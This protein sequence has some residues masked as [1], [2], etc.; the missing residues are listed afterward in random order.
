MSIH[1]DIFAVSSSAIVSAYAKYVMITKSQAAGSKHVQCCSALRDNETT[2]QEHNAFS[3][4]EVR[5]SK[6]AQIQ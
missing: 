5:S 2:K 6:T 4:F 1:L 3:T